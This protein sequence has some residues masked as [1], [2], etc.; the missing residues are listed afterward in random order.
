MQTTP[1][2]K[3]ISSASYEWKLHQHHGW[4]TL[5]SEYCDS[6]AEFDA[7]C[8]DLA[9]T[10]AQ[11]SD[12]WSSQVGSTADILADQGQDQDRYSKQLREALESI[13]QPFVL[14]ISPDYWTDEAEGFDAEEAALE[15]QAE[16][17]KDAGYELL[18]VDRGGHQGQT[19]V[20]NV[21]PSITASFDGIEVEWKS[22]DSCDAEDL[23]KLC[24]DNDD[25]DFADWRKSS[26]ERF[27]AAADAINEELEK[28]TEA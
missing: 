1:E 18:T 10:K 3:V 28:L 21:K 5:H 25:D 26:R 7:A 14:V 12:S 13:T 16:A 2:I 24:L 19:S 27:E 23:I 8:D 9:R 15:A 4:K 22:E 20:V 11:D 6:R 17:E